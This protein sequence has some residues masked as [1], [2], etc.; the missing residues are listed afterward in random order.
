MALKNGRIPLIRLLPLE[1]RGVYWIYYVEGTSFYAKQ[2]VRGNNSVRR[3]DVRA[4]V[5][6][7]D[8]PRTARPAD[9]SGGQLVTPKSEHMFR[10]CN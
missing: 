8:D 2:V 6:F 5:T 7:G 4:I 3:I 9:D 1:A 10:V